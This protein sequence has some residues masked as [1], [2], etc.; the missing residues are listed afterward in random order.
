MKKKFWMLYRMDEQTAEPVAVCYLDFTRFN[1]TRMDDREAFLERFGI[2]ARV[3]I[4]D[5]EEVDKWLNAI[6]R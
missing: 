3:D 1:K 2:P 5:Q 4:V 6:S